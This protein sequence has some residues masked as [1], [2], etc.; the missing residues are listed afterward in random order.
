MQLLETKI[1]YS[2]TDIP[3]QGAVIW[4]HGLGAD[5]NDFVPLVPELKLNSAIKFVFPNA[6]IMPITINNGYQMRAWYDIIDF[7]DLHREVDSQG[8]V[9]SVQHINALIQQLK[10]EGLTSQQIILAGFSQGGVISYYTALTSDEPL[11]GLLVLS[12]YLPD[13]SLIDV[14]KLQH[15]QQLPICICHGS[16]DPVVNI[17]L[18]RTACQYLQGLGLN[19]EWYEYPMEH[20]LCYPQIQQISHWLDKRFAK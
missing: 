10:A 9:A 7:S 19:Y 3:L 14:A 12:S 5:C 20:S 13:P 2:R 8:I 16:A 11:A 18:A 6:P 15:Q 17:N 4:L 1:V